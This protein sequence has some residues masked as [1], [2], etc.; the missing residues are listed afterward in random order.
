MARG[1]VQRKPTNVSARPDLIAEAKELG[2]NLSQVFEAA[3]ERSVREARK[4]RWVEENRE[5]FKA[6]D[7]FVERHGVFSSGK[8]LF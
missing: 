5:A 3:V 1:A 4:Q 8:R 7:E 2:I 6:Y